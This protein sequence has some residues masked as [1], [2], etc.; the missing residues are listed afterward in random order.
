MRRWL[1]LGALGAVLAVAGCGVVGNKA[2]VAG[3]TA[4]APSSGTPGAGS[5][6]GAAGGAAG[7]SSGGTSAGTAGGN[8]GSASAGSGSSGS[9]G[10]GST[11][12]TSDG[13]SSSGSG[14][15]GSSSSNGGATTGSLNGTTGSSGTANFGTPSGSAPSSLPAP[16]AL[17]TAARFLD[18][19]SFGPTAG[20]LALVQA[21]GL[22]AYLAQQFALAPTLLPAIPDPLPAQYLA[23]D[24]SLSQDSCWGSEWWG[25]ALTAP[26]QLRQRTAFAL[27]HM[28]V[29]SND[30]TGG[31]ATTLFYNLLLQDAFGNWRHL[32]E[33]M[34]LSPAMGQFL[35]MANS[36]KAPAGQIA[37]ENF[38]RE[39]LQL[40]SIGPNL[41]NPDGTPQTDADGNLMP[42][43]T[44]AQVQAFARAFTGWSY[45]PGPGQAPISFPVYQG[46][47]DLPM[48]AV[49]EQHDAAA[50]I[51]LNGTVLP[52]GQSARG[53]LEGALDNIFAHPNLPPFVARQL[54][55]HLVSSHPSPAYVARVAAVFVDNGSGVRGD[56]QAVL[57]AILLDPEARAGDTVPAFDGGHLREPLL[58]GASVL[59]AVG[60]T[61]N[62][63]DP[64]TPWPY[65][66]LLWQANTMGQFPMNAPS[67]FGFFPPGYVIPQTSLNAPEFGIENTASVAA[68]LSFA[69]LVATNQLW[70]MTVNLGP[71]S[72]LYE[73]A[74]QSPEALIH[75]LDTMYLHGQ[76][77]QEMYSTLA[78]VLAPIADKES[79]VQ[80]A[81]YL[82]IT[83][84]Q[85]KIS[86]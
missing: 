85:Y 83:S 19:A 68:R 62:P 42:S 78:N 35:N 27:S 75:L 64:T 15:N 63:A 14:S 21:K 32:M 65:T 40:F 67:V 13:N 2:V 10:G 29:I 18:Q 55:Q 58:Y 59:R 71:G 33:D 51:L 9:N 54:I 26:D 72:P 37:N 44:Q 1:A 43:Y 84:S 76:M 52:A 60:F 69:D 3:G 17:T 70:Q 49:D 79:E 81:L 11:S 50:K 45:V 22:N 25:A 16:V 80:M 36:A 6:T 8:G 34:V 77:T 24:P 20:D 4:A 57:R 53:D 38:A 86:H 61:P 47:M 30:A 28:Y 56:L 41:L 74:A 7:G 39:N 48:G 73:A 82:V 12:G 23:K 66:F 31:R 5:G 46:R